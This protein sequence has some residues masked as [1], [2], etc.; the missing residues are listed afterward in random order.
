MVTTIVQA[1]DLLARIASRDLT[2]PAEVDAAVADLAQVTAL[3]GQLPADRRGTLPEDAAQAK[4]QIAE[5][6]AAI[7]GQPPR[8]EPEHVAR[9]WLDL[10][11]SDL[12][13]QYG[14]ADN[15]HGRVMEIQKSFTVHC[16]QV[17]ACHYA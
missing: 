5:A 2:V 7:L 8:G 15:P 9:P 4:R 3:I 16:D 13:D 11:I 10:V 12:Y 17:A 1:Q 14:D 6:V